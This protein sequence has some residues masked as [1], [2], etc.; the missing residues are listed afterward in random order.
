MTPEDLPPELASIVRMPPP[1]LSDPTRPPGMEP[2]TASRPRRQRPPEPALR[3]RSA[4]ATQ[5]LERPDP[6]RHP[7][8]KGRGP[9]DGANTLSVPDSLA[10]IVSPPA[11]GDV[12]IL[13]RSPGMLAHY[14]ATQTLELA[15]LLPREAAV[16][17]GVM[18]IARTKDSVTVAIADPTD[19]VARTVVITRMKSIGIDHVDFVPMEG[20]AIQERVR[21]GFALTPLNL[22]EVPERPPLK[23]LVIP[24]AAA[25]AAGAGVGEAEAATPTVAPGVDELGDL[26]FAEGH[27]TVE[28]LTYAR[29]ESVREGAT[30][31]EFV[32]H[33][34]LV[35]EAT[36]GRALAAL[37]ELDYVEPATLT[38]DDAVV[39]GLPS[40]FA[41]KHSVL[42]WR[43]HDGITDIAV[44]EPD[45]P[46][47][48]ARL[49]EHYG[50]IRL[51]V[52]P[53]MAIITALEHAHAPDN[54]FAATSKLAE[55]RPVDSAATTFTQRQKLVAAII[56]VLGLICFVIWPL[57]TFIAFNIA[58]SLFY[59][60]SSAYKILLARHSFLNE[61][62]TPTTPEEV[63]A[64][65]DARLPVFT[66]LMPMYREAAIVHTLVESIAKLDYPRHK[67]DVKLLLEEDDEETPA[68]LAELDL[69]PHF[70]VVIVPDALPKTK[71]KACNYGLLLARGEITVIYDAE[72][73]PD[74]DQLKKV[75]VAFAKGDPSMVCV[76]CKLN[77]YNR[78]QNLLTR[79]FTTEYSQWFDIFL[80]G[81]DS[82]DVPIP[83][84]GTS[85][86]FMTAELVSLGA[87]DPYNV[88]EDADLGIR[89][90]KNNWRTGVVDST[91]YE[92]ANPDLHNWI[93]QRSR[94]IKGYMQTWLVHM[95]H[96]ITL[97]RTLGVKSFLSFQLTIGGTCVGFLLN[98]F[99]WLLTV[100]FILSEAGVIRAAFPG[101]VYFAASFGLIIG[102]FTFMYLNVAGSMRRGYF[103]LVKYALIS[104][105]YWVLMSWAAWKGLIQLITKPHYW[106]KT[107]HG[108]ATER[109]TD[110]HTG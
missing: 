56:G 47:M 78:T 67:L 73:E 38:V 64:L 24:V 76:Q 41:F 13:R 49:Q 60:T 104:P 55:S 80:P 17:F 72:D 27:L 83:L 95:R 79:W 66:I 29:E 12:R 36:A 35:T 44:A 107:E 105:L 84:G 45:D 102:N 101:I 25:A 32:C 53:K 92:E 57:N 7:A 85:N 34:G 10:G 21:E 69:L 77:Y 42:P 109:T 82:Q 33:S 91:T 54:I 5:V 3:P 89:L 15:A 110:H 96:P 59:L 2:G 100:A 43:E 81:L 22:P 6:D 88:T 37:H 14:D 74:P 31:R 75:V 4:E 39:R 16:L 86:H 71:P 62:V 94:W 50:K 98:P 40:R 97:L 52:A 48:R 58:A 46:Q 23:P 108:L 8:R 19:E 28:E 51:S 18:A 93:R 26:L 90:S 103:D 1:G 106:E 30:L 70:H 61:I 63:A 20:P 99:Y 9:H 68:A 87:W 11:G 65:D